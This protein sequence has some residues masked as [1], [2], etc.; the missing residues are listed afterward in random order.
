MPFTDADKI[1]QIDFPEQRVPTY[2]KYIL[3]VCYKLHGI[4]PKEKPEKLIL[5]V[6]LFVVMSAS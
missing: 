4:S 2:S 6:L 3:L 5:L 1:G